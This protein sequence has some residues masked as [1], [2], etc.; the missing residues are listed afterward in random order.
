MY[1]QEDKVYEESTP[2][3]SRAVGGS[4]SQNFIDRAWKNFSQL[5]PPTFDGTMKEGATHSCIFN[6]SMLAGISVRTDCAYLGVDLRFENR[7]TTID[8]IYLPMIEIDVV[9]DMDWLSTN[10]VTLNCAKKIISLPVYTAPTVT[11]SQSRFLSIIQAKKYIQ[12]GCQAYMMFFFVHATYDEGIERIEVVNEF[13]K[14]FSK[15]MSGLL[16][17]QEMEF[18]I[19]LIPETEPISKAPYQMSPSKLAELKKQLEELLEKGFIRLSMFA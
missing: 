18:S 14:V 17:E 6:V 16:L 5:Y 8:L 9:V 12:Q 4:G 13:L 10:N 3:Q 19:D 11:P 7:S 1:E 2:K 15:E